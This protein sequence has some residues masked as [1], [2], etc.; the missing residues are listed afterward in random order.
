MRVHVRFATTFSLSIFGLL[1]LVAGTASAAPAIGWKEADKGLHVAE[2]QT[3]LNGDRYAITLVKIDPG[4]YSFQ[5]LCATEHGKEPLSVKEW[6]IKHHL[7]AAVN[8]S[9]FQADG[10]TSIDFMKNFGH[11]NNPRLSRDNTILAF[12]PVDKNLPQVQL[13]DRECQDFSDLRSKYRS[14]VQG[15]RM[16]SCNGRNVWSRQDA[17]WSMLAMGMD[18]RGN[19]LFLFCRTPGSVHDFIEILLSLPLSL[20]SA[21]YLEGGP[22]ASLYLSTPKITL[23]KYCTLGGLESDSIK[24]ALP[25][26]NV[27]GIAK[28]N[29]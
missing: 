1:L 6:A 14:F 19:I 29:R 10:L 4:A 15:I 24:F 5:L 11:V 2:V 23:E 27:I 17:K 8:A 13:I 12:N 7:V 16:I 18:A 20:K 22:Q 9:M 25:I 26:P 3:V 21:M 28:K